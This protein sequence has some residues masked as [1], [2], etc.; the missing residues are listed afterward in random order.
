MS[1]RYNIMAR[2]KKNKAPPSTPAPSLQDDRTE[3][4]GPTVDGR[5]RCRDRLGN[6]L[7]TLGAKRTFQGLQF[8]ELKQNSFSPRWIL[9]GTSKTWRGTDAA[10]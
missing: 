2:M 8:S 5:T 1:N 7:G 6:K 3:S 10:H 9:K 4:H